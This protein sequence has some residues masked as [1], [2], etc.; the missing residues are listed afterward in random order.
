MA[1]SMWLGPV[2][3]FLAGLLAGEELVIRYG[4]RAPIASLE[5]RPH[6]AVRQALIRRL[7]VL[8][9]ALI[10]PTL[11]SAVAVTVADR[12]RP[13]VVVRGAG[14]L[15]LLVLVLVTLLGT[16]PINAAALA[17]APEAPPA[18]WQAQVRRWERLDTVRCWAALAAFALFL[19]A[20]SG[21]PGE[22]R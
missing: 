13:Q 20:G 7:R 9:P 11:G 15:A 18:D 21:R 16:A 2:N 4:V 12:R 17:W 22:R 1:I 5:P 19:A 8:V 6:I 3:L 10:G 14:V